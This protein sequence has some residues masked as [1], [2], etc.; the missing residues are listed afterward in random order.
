MQLGNFILASQ[1][2]GFISPG[3]FLGNGEFLPFL[4]NDFGD[5]WERVLGVFRAQYRPPMVVVEHVS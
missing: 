3:I 5:F 1:V 2:F 4:A